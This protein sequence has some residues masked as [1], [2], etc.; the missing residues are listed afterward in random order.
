MIAIGQHV[1]LKQDWDVFPLGIVLAG[2]TGTVT[3]I[4]DGA[5]HV[6]LDMHF[7]DLDEW[8]NVLHIGTPDFDV[9]A[10][11]AFYLQVIP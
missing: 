7:P 3:A 6:K 11:S 5:I 4:R 10:L 8:Q 9:E 2:N 1:Q